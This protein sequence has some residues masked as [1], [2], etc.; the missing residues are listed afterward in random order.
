[1]EDK[2]KLLNDAL[3][4]INLLQVKY[5]KKSE[6]K[7]RY[8]KINGEE[9]TSLQ[10]AED[11]YGVG[12]IT[13]AQLMRVQ[14]ALDP[15]YRSIPQMHNYDLYKIFLEIGNELHDQIQKEKGKRMEEEHDTD[16]RDR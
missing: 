9:C 7:I 14:H 6:R 13:S 3:Y 15:D 10:D 16:H 12:S 8:P 5:K 11:A 1:M 2:I 4:E